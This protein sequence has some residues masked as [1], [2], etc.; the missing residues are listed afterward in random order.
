M[1]TRDAKLFGSNSGAVLAFA[2]DRVKN[3]VDFAR[4][5]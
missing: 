1:L 5:A 4:L 3:E 2:I